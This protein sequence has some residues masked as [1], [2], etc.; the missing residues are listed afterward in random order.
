MNQPATTLRRLAVALALDWTPTDSGRRGRLSD[1]F[2]PF[3]ASVVLRARRA[4]FIGEAVN[5]FDG[6]GG[7]EA[8]P[9]ISVSLDRPLD[10]L[11][12]DVERRLVGPYRHVY[13]PPALDRKREQDARA[14]AVAAIE[15]QARTVTGAEFRDE[16]RRPRQARVFAQQTA[17]RP[18][19]T[20][21]IVIRSPTSVDVQIGGL[22]PAA[23]LDVLRSIHT[24]SPAPTHTQA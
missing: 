11:A 2:G 20:L 3:A 12:R 15:E 24:P 19:A 21:Q 22:T 18:Y 7:A 8:P 10:V 6:R 4:E 5:E 16:W 23:A 13:A 9:H 17:R 14:A 1:P